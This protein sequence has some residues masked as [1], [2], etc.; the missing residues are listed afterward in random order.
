MDEEKKV[1]VTTEVKRDVFPHVY[2]ELAS[3]DA[4]ERG[5]QTQ[6]GR[7][8]NYDLMTSMLM[9]AFCLEAFLNYL[10]HKTLQVWEEIERLGPEQ[11]L[12]LLAEIIG[13]EVDDSRRPFQTFKRIT[14]FRNS[15]VHAKPD[16]EKESHSDDKTEQ[17]LENLIESN[18]ISKPLPKS[19][20]VE[21]YVQQC[22]VENA[23]RFCEDMQVMIEELSSCAGIDA[24]SPEVLWETTTWSSVAHFDT[25]VGNDE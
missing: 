9:T 17:E 10:G 6:G 18:V 7:L 4:L 19:D 15:V 1:I 5:K 25:S 24:A 16:F 8:F 20:W 2:L 22:T 3:L 12:S 23:E 21:E 14:K 13:Y 11:K